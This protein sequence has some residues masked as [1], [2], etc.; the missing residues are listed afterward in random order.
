VHLTSIIVC[1]GFPY[2]TK[3]IQILKKA[4]IPDWMGSTGHIMAFFSRAEKPSED[5][6]GRL[7]MM[8]KKGLTSVAFQN[9][10]LAFLIYKNNSAARYIYMRI[11]IA[12]DNVRE[13]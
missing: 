8:K 2:P 3:Q 5:I 7:F 11:S 10:E 6:P 9:P 4:V 12:Q 1:S 13:K